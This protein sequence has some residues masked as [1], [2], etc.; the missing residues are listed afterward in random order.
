MKPAAAALALLW[1]AL[2]PAA[3]RA[4]EAIAFAPS[5]R[6][7]DT[8]LALHR[9]ASLHYRFLF[10]VYDAA[11]Y[12]GRGIAPARLLDDVPRRLEIRYRYGFRAEDFAK[13]TREGIEKNVDA[14]VYARLAPEI[15][16]FN[17]LYRDVAPGDRYALSYVPGRGTELAWNGER[18]GVVEG[19]EFSRALFSIWFG[20]Q[21][22]DAG[23]KRD[24]LADSPQ[25]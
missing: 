14:A 2:A 25:R 5:V 12:L 8:A 24:L 21:P 20:P 13:A 4:S 10:H 7:G 18:L 11:L 6:S 23:L 9:T 17:A 1:L 15:A 19:A 16:R 3:A 22:F